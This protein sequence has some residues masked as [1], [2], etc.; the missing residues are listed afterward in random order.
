MSTLLKPAPMARIAVLGLKK[1]R[2][3][4]I[5]IL[6]EMNVIQLEP[7]SKEADSFLMSEH[8]SDLHR[9]ISDQLLRIRGLI[10]SI[11]PTTVQR[12]TRFSSFEELIKTIKSI[13][14]DGKIASL[15]RERENLLTEMKE[16]ENNIKLLE[17]FSFFPEDLRI[18][19]L[20]F[21]R[22]FFGRV[23]SEK[24]DAFKNIL[25]SNG[26]PV[27]LYPHEQKKLIYFVLVIP[28]HF[29]SNTLASAVNLHGVHL[30]PVPKLKGKPREIIHDQQK[31]YNNLSAK[32]NQINL[33]LTDISKSHYTFLKGA[34]E[35]LE[36]E[37]K[38]LEVIANLK[39]TNDAFALEGWIPRSKLENV[40]TAFSNYSEGTVIYELETR[41]S[42]P[43]LLENPKR[44]KVFESFIRFYSLP[45]GT[46]FDPTLIFGLIF[47]IFYGLMIG[48]VGYGLVI[49]L[50]S[51]WVIRR[52]Q[53]G[54]RDLNIMPGFLRNFAKTILRPSQ[55]VKL[56][57]VMIPGC[58]FTIILGFLFDL[59]FGFNL[60]AY[61][62]SYLNDTFGLN[63]PHD[64]AFLNPIGTFGLRKLLLLS[65]YI[66]LGMVSFGLVLGILNSLRERQ[67][68]HV[69]SKVGWLLF[70]WGIALI[71][72]ALI[73]HVNI[74]PL[75][76]V[77]GIIYF[78]LIFGGVG[79]MFYG[80][81]L[82][83]LMELPSI[84]SHILSY[85][86]IV[87]ILLASVILAHVID[88][89]FLRSL[90]QSIP[91]SILGIMIFI[92]GHLFNIII[93]VFEPG[94]QGARL[95]YVEFFSKFYHGSGRQ[96]KPFGSK[97][98]FTIDQYNIE[99]QKE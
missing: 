77:Q 51:L 79:L 12:K 26:I 25:E 56:A 55:M 41:E 49:L 14:I 6:H 3:E 45:S 89:I 72:L 4:I 10:N 97:R 70:G 91:Y 73:N 24:L 39:G 18:L 17:E 90:D 98:R 68:K 61:L 29:P 33:Q 31:L 48:D 94:I 80:E 85:T 81:G 84:I 32:L 71:G 21:A 60:N 96:F 37:N 82:R 95:I 15:E 65:G 52:V 1:Y 75:D 34:E 63:F 35:Q 83:A 44:F 47:P 19:N 46:E 62:F 67:F 36:I 57:K 43:T 66:G 86:R 54:K 92:I 50:V 20:S 64:G 2:Q 74:N 23:A 40:K 59:Y 28:P 16:A 76:S 9:E 53:G 99:K 13:D 93:G 5:S 58:I 27:I 42:P 78:I 87:G 22:S 88:F 69:I 11:P 8:E 7:L 30:E 38:K